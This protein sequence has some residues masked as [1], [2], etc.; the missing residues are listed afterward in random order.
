M[1]AVLSLEIPSSSFI[2]IHLW[3]IDFQHKTLTDTL[4]KNQHVIV[5]SLRGWL[6]YTPTYREGQLCACV[7]VFPPFSSLEHQTVRT[8]CTESLLFFTRNSLNFLHAESFFSPARAAQCSPTQLR[9]HIC[10]ELAE[11]FCPRC[12]NS[13]PFLIF[14]GTRLS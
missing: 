14:L 13:L 8:S 2:W 11:F 10:K 7:S 6:T 3:R 1:F 4:F 12:W 9:R 5:F